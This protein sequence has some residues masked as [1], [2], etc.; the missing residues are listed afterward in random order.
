MDNGIVKV[1]LSKPQGTVTEIEYGGIDNMLESLN[2]EAHRGYVNNCPQIPK[3]ILIQ[4]DFLLI[5][6]EVLFI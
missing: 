4:L 2:L 5:K 6:G 3:K 1:M